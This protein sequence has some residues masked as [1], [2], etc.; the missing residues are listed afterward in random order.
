MFL[1]ALKIMFIRLL[2]RTTLTLSSPSKH[3]S[4]TLISNLLP[5]PNYFTY[6][7]H[8]Y[9]HGRTCGTELLVN[10]CKGLRPSVSFTNDLYLNVQELD[11][12]NSTGYYILLENLC[13]MENYKEPERT[14]EA[15]FRL[16]LK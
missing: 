15:D 5:L 9:H 6:Q 14:Q 8:M 4:I 1:R 12:V 10:Y 3:A 13:Y 2:L 16:Y 11:Q 7:R